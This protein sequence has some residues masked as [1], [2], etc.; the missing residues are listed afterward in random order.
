MASTTNANQN[1]TLSI[2]QRLSISTEQEEVLLDG[3]NILNSNNI[4]N[5]LD[6]SFIITEVL[7][8]FNFAKLSNTDI[9]GNIT[10]TNGAIYINDQILIG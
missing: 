9:C 10:L 2:T 7:H 6:M 4:N 5:A 8:K 3:E 1:S